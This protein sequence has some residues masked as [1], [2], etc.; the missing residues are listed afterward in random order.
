MD[1]KSRFGIMSLLHYNAVRLHYDFEKFSTLTLQ[2]HSLKK[3]W[4]SKAFQGIPGHSK[5][6]QG[7]PGHSRA[8]QGIPGHSKAF[9]GIPGHS[10]AF[11]DIP[12][13][14]YRIIVHS[15][16]RD[17]KR[18]GLRGQDNSIKWHGMAWNDFEWH[19][20]TW[21]TLE[22]HG[23]PWKALECPGMTWNDMECRGMTWNDIE[24]QIFFW[25]NDSNFFTK[26]FSKRRRIHQNSW[27]ALECLECLGMP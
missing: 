5:A 6:F 1:V 3:I 9:Q 15:K 13:H 7:I 17:A 12:R 19:G 24:C 22:W 21:N 26:L 20:M 25:G 8:F 23:M 16:T 4:H 27:N 2:C 10:K 14:S 11:Q 18:S